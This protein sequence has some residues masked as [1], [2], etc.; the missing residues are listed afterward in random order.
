[1]W[2]LNNKGNV[3]I[4]LCLVFTALLGFTAYVVDI[5]FVYVEKVKLSNAIDSA[6]LAASLE[7]PTDATKAR[8]VA[9]EYLQKNNVDSSKVS[10]I[11]SAD[12]KSI[13]MDG[14]KNVSHFF[15]PII[16]IDNSNINARTKAIIGPVKSVK[17][18]TRPFAVEKYDFSYGDVVTLKRGAGD[19]YHGNY[20]AVALG[21]TGASVFESNSLYG[22]SGTITVG[23]MINTETGNMEGAV[24]KIKNYINSESSSFDN[25]KRNSIRLWTLPLVDSLNVDGILV[26]GFGE[27]YV[28]KI[29]IN[30]GKIEI[31]G[32]FIRYV[33]NGE[34]DMT[35]SDTGAYGAKLV[36]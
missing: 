8:N 1:M 35:L 6:V 9:R 19:G 10:I 7:L 22:Y 30:S 2:R 23:D 16:G 13:Q 4:I 26:V 12:N 25:F 15:A 28:E 33:L 21:G 3:A 29:I 20:G 32:R 34:I 36:K 11:I 27:F 18:G 5:G 31:Q 17:G 14:V 24:N